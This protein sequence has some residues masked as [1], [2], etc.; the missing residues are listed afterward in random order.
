ME[1]SSVNGLSSACTGDL[2]RA[3]IV[4]GAGRGLGKMEN[5]RRLVGLSEILD[6][7]VGGTRGAV[8]A[9]WISND[10]E[11]G[12]SGKRVRPALY[13]ACGVSGSNFHTIGMEHSEYIVAINP[14]MKARIHELANISI[15]AD[16][17][18]CIE[19]MRGDLAAMGFNAQKDNAVSIL[20]EYF[21]KNTV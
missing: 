13:L 20:K 15:Y 16:V 21:I 6:A 2:V 12:L 4:V 7:Q 10:R 8:D 9:G 5:F 17:N 18:S 14:D 19:K 3:R 1:A 11:I